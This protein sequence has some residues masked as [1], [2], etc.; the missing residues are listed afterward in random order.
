MRWS[1][2]VVSTM[3]WALWGVS[4]CSSSGSSSGSS[5]NAETAA[6]GLCK[7]DFQVLDQTGWRWPNAVVVLTI[8]GG[9]FGGAH[10]SPASDWQGLTTMTQLPCHTTGVVS[11]IGLDGLPLPPAWQ[12]EYLVNT[13]DAGTHEMQVHSQNPDPENPNYHAPGDDCQ[14]K[15]VAFSAEGFPLIGLKFWIDLLNGEARKGYSNFE[16]VAFVNVPCHRDAILSLYSES[17]DGFEIIPI[18]DGSSEIQNGSAKI[19]TDEAW[20]HDYNVDG[21]ADDQHRY[22]SCN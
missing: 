17:S 21:C 20:E 2:V 22:V 14:I 18:F 15:G 8:D 10:F 19:N 9:P 12:G 3:A 16:G 11:M 6:D 5:T 7:L 1:T 4:G 13:D